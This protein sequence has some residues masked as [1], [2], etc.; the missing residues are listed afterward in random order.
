MID[1]DFWKFSPLTES[2]ASRQ[3]PWNTRRDIIHAFLL[4]KR[5]EEELD[6]L[7]NAMQNVL[8][9]WSKRIAAISSEVAQFHEKKSDQFNAGAIS[10]LK[11]LLWDSELQL[12]RADALLGNVVKFNDVPT[13]NSDDISSDESDSDSEGLSDC[14]DSE[15]EC[16]SQ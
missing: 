8:E 15:D 2:P 6:L 12:T 5:C 9:Y 11:H 14:S 13:V 7:K 16:C 4:A 3:V 1:S 10:S